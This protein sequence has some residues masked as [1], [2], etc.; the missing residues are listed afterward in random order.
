MRRRS[1]IAVVAVLLA[2]ALLP[3]LAAPALARTAHPAAAAVPSPAAAEAD[4]VARIR[5]TRNL[6][7]LSVD[8]ADAA[9]RS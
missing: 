9:A 8:G 5:R 6:G 2:G 3:V 7:P 4:F 1:R